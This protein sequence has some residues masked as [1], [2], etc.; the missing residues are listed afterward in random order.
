MNTLIFFL[1]YLDC[2]C[3]SVSETNTARTLSE[4]MQR[5]SQTKETFNKI[6]NTPPTK[7]TFTITAEVK[8]NPDL[9][10]QVLL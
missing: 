2:P 10:C 5:T 9:V 4:G 8:G 7:V 1:I 3:L 6:H